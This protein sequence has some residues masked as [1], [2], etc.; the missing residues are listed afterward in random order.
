VAIPVSQFKEDKD[1]FVL[2]GASEEMIKGMPKF[3]YAES[4]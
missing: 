2:E 3:E 1:R 4:R